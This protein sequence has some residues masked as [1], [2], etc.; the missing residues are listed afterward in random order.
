MDYYIGI[1][2]GTTSTK[3]VAFSATGQMLAQQSAGYP[4]LHPQEDRSE[5]EPQKIFN[6]VIDCLLKISTQLPEHNPLL[7]SFS[8]AMHSL[9]LIDANDDPLTGCIIWADNRASA[10]ADELRH[11]E[12]GKIFYQLSGV[13][14][15]A[16]SPFCKLLWF[17]K[18][19]PSLF[20]RAVKF[21]GIK[22]FIF[23]RLFKKYIID[24]AIASATGLLNSRLLQWEGK[25]LA[26]AGI[27]E[28]QLST[29]VSTTNIGYLQLNEANST[30]H[31]LNAFTK[32]AFVIGSSDGG[33]ANLGSGATVE[34]S[35]SVTIGTSSAVRVVTNEV[36]TDAQMRSF[37]YHLTGQQYI[38]GGASNN[39]AVVIQWLKE[40]ILQN[41]GT[42]AS[43]INTAEAVPPGSNGLLFLPYILGE[44]API[45]NS[46]ARGVFWGLG[47]EHTTSHMVRAAMEAVVYNTYAIGKIL[48]EKKKI[49]TIFANGGFTDSGFW[50]QMLADIFNL[51]VFVPAIEESSALGAVMVG[52]KALEIPAAFD[53]TKG[54]TYQPVNVNQ[55]IY[56]RQFNKM[57][58]LYQLVK[59]EF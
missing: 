27:E 45:W 31:P 44:R 11:T 18:N 46:A 54:K 40:N 21:I 42:Y 29:I 52:M 35:M 43:F 55:E 16:M 3:A 20:G 25:I 41:A 47:I 49:S 8:A 7:V 32:T 5:Q 37:C 26:F 12:T 50:V 36:I 19:D 22:E 59:S 53:F 4:I 24:T 2:I 17:K 13:P 15:H 9:I 28:K 48:M 38:I 57:E 10:L 56:L 33:L 58:H 39:G 51:P 23:H 34:G 14:V 1:D 30:P 6:A